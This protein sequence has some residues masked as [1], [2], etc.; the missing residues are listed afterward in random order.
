MIGNDGTNQQNVTS[1]NS[2]AIGYKALNHKACDRTNPYSSNK[3]AIYYRLPKPIKALLLIS[4]G[5]LVGSAPQKLINA[6]EP[7]DFDILVESKELYQIACA[8]ANE[9]MVS[10]NTF[11]GLKLSLNGY[12]VD[13]WCE[14]LGHF[15][16]LASKFDYVFNLKRS[17]L[18]K[19]ES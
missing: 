4:E 2:V 18:I 14:D 12:S 16:G 13:I 8:S 17:K 7:K 1:I 11:G 10:V 5:W 3:A 15:L 9:W 19:N 6:E